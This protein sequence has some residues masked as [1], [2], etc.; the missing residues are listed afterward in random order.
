MCKRQ[1]PFLV[2]GSVKIGML[3]GTF[4]PPHIAHLIAA[5]LAMGQFGLD[6]MLFVPAAQSPL[7]T[8]K[9]ISSANDRLEMTRLAIQDNP[10]FEVSRV[11]LDREGAS[12][13]IDT[14]KALHQQLPPTEIY[15]LIGRDQYEQFESWRQ[16]YDIV[17][18]VRLVVMDRPGSP[19]KSSTGFDSAVSY[20]KMPLLEISATEIRRRV[21]KGESIRYQVPEAVRT[22]IAEHRLYQ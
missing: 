1:V 15:L 20:L 3:G 17:K 21:A 7:K 2:I 6:K 8:R 5:E 12:Y 9:D 18:L 19:A 13:T 16:P 11:E 14:I 10:K 4:D 22:Y